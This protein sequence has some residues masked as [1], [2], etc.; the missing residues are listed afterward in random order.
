MLNF[1]GNKFQLI[2]T[3]VKLIC[4]CELLEKIN[5][6]QHEIERA[7]RIIRIIA[8][9]DY[10]YRLFWWC[11][12]RLPR[13]RCQDTHAA[14]EPFSATSKRDFN[15][16]MADEQRRVNKDPRV[17]RTFLLLFQAA[18]LHVWSMCTLAVFF[19]AIF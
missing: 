6:F 9:H 12:R 2:Q 17:K 8:F 13:R 14:K 3:T 16:A 7:S 18:P 19:F 15:Q 5:L 4:S 1:L 11:R 10:R